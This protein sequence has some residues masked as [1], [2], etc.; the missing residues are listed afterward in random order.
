MM[1]AYSE[2]FMLPLSHDEVVHLE[3]LAARLAC[4]GSLA[5][6]C[7]SAAALQLHVDLSRQETA[8]HGRGVRADWAS[9][10]FAQPCLGSLADD[11]MH[12]GVQR[13][14][15]DL[16]RLYATIA[17]LHRYEFEHAAAL[18]GWI[19]T[20]PR[21][22]CLSFARFDGER[23]AMVV[24]LNFTPVPRITHRIGV[25]RPGWYREVFNSDSMYYGG[26]NLGNPP[27]LRGAAGEL[28]G[29][30]LFAR[31]HACHRSV[32]DLDAELASATDS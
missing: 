12:A 7:Q 16:N 31:T 30:A 17:A 9:G 1:Y 29:P 22:R 4:R 25:P 23:C 14:V 11:P 3:A 5:A 27:A 6:V 15:S 21:I 13:L 26:G 18:A 32:A 8:V 2:N 24:A 19:A 10:I 20:T 28:Q